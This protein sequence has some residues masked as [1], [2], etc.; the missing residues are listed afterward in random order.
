MKKYKSILREKNGTVKHEFTHDTKEGAEKWCDMQKL[1][2]EHE[3]K[4][5]GWKTEIEE[6]D[7]EFAKPAGFDEYME[8]VK[9]EVNRIGKGYTCNFM[10]RGEN[11]H[12]INGVNHFCF[13]LEGDKVHPLSVGGSRFC[14][15][16][17][18]SKE[19]FIAELKNILLTAEECNAVYRGIAGNLGMS[20]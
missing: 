14:Y 19:E 8:Q 13:S 17:D 5:A 6:F 15:P 16:N 3:F 2:N 7:Y 10:Y 12:H 9:A 4:Y 1:Y 11:I 18:F 20:K